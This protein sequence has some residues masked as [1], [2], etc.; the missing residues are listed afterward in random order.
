MQPLY[1]AALYTEFVL[2]SN[3]F[4]LSHLLEDQNKF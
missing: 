4:T 3:T 2:R 1:I